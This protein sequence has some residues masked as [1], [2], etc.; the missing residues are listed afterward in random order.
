MYICR[1]T[2]RGFAGASWQINAVIAGDV[3]LPRKTKRFDVNAGMLDDRTSVSGWCRVNAQQHLINSATLMTA[4]AHSRATDRRRAM[5]PADCRQPMILGHEA[6]YIMTEP[7][8]R[9]HMTRRGE[10]VRFLH[11]RT[12][13]D[14][15]AVQ[16]Q[17]APHA[18]DQRS[19][20]QKIV[21]SSNVS[22]SLTPMVAKTTGLLTPLPSTS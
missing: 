2:G 7:A 1:Q 11:Q 15:H 9:P 14:R 4:G 3:L 22:A 21:K 17:Q 12:K 8:S 20:T 13:A 6:F 18:I 10:I 16:T 19:P 5:M